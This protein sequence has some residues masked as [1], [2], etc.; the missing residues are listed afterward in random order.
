MYSSSLLATHSQEFIKNKIGVITLPRFNNHISRPE[1]GYM[2]KGYGLLT[3]CLLGGFR[4][5]H[6][7][8]KT[9]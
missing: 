2:K 3:L 6:K 9:K 1:G 4:E 8:Q 7:S 5:E